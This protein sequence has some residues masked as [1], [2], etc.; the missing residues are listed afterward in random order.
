MHHGVPADQSVGVRGGTGTDDA[1][2]HVHY[3]KRT[4]DD[5]KHLGGTFRQAGLGNVQVH[6]APLTFADPEREHAKDAQRQAN[7]AGDD[8]YEQWIHGSSLCCGKTGKQ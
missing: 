2:D 3:D 1:V 7:E 6:D 4:P 8:T 5:G